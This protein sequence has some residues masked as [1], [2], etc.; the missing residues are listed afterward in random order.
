MSKNDNHKV[1]DDLNWSILEE[2]QKKRGF[3]T[4]E[5]ERRV[6]L[7]APAVADRIGKGRTWHH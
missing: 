2:L 1:I 6:G 7:S 5:I 3:S 4:T